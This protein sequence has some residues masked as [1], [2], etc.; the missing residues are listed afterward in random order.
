[1][2][3]NTL[4]CQQSKSQGCRNGLVRVLVIVKEEV[5]TWFLILSVGYIV[6]DLP[7]VNCNQQN[8]GVFFL[9]TFY[10]LT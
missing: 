1:M 7:K 8:E 6:G 2:P 3:F 9:L 10:L 5:K 4:F